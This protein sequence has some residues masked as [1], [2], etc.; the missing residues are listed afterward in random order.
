MEKPASLPSHTHGIDFWMMHGRQQVMISIDIFKK[1]AALEIQ[2]S[3][4][5]QSKHTM[6]AT[7]TFMPYSGSTLFLLSQMADIMTNL[8]TDGGKPF[9]YAVTQTIKSLDQ[10]LIPLDTSS[11]IRPRTQVK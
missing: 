4:L 3:T 7:R 1:C 6:T 5:E 11:N 2:F 10:G 9:G 8:Y